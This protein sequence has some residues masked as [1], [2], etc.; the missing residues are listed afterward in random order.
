MIA[1]HTAG[2]CPLRTVD[3]IATGTLSGP[4]QETLGC[5]LE[6]T[7]N[8]INELKLTEAAG[9]GSTIVRRY[10]EDGDTVEFRAQAKGGEC[11]GNV[12]FGVCT[13][14]ILPCPQSKYF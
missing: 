2:G 7:R 12:G 13:G 3:L 10:L 6:L 1:H 8:G 11:Q 14:Q 4:S 9:G 5:L